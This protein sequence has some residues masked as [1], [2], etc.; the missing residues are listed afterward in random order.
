[1]SKKKSR[2]QSPLCDVTFTPWPPDLGFLKQTGSKVWNMSFF[3]RDGAFREWEYFSKSAHWLHP[4]Q[5]LTTGTPGHPQEA[6]E[7]KGLP[8]TPWELQHN[9]RDF[10]KCTFVLCLYLRR[11]VLPSVEISES[12]RQESPWRL[13]GSQAESFKEKR[14][15]SK[16]EILLHPSRHTP[17]QEEGGGEQSGTLSERKSLWASERVSERAGEREKE[18]KTINML[19]VLCRTNMWWGESG[20]SRW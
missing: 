1:M 5:Q 16:R 19:I 18:H 10:P 14:L 13:L 12:A 9:Y 3:R 15:F 11:S 20:G 4:L 7:S 17:K 6:V 2:M 8:E